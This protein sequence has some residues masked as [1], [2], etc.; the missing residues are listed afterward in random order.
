MW[1]LCLTLTGHGWVISWS[2]S[3]NHMRYEIYAKR[4]FTWR[5]S[6]LPMIIHVEMAEVQRKPCSYW[7]TVRYSKVVSLKKPHL[8]E[9]FEQDFFA[10]TFPGFYILYGNT[11]GSFRIWSF[12]IFFTDY[13]RAVWQRAINM[14]NNIFEFLFA[15]ENI[16]PISIYKAVT[17]I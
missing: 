1:I 12:R 13:R 6:H 3:K 2:F 16:F 17:A 11:K 14:W 7:H 4:S 8:Q 5:W 10:P 9:N 15:K